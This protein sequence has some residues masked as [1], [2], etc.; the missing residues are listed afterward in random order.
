MAKVQFELNLPGLNELMKSPEM[1]SILDA[2]G[3]AVASAAG[4]D[5]GHRVHQASFV[6]ICNVYPDSKEA[7]KENYEENTL[8][9]A[10]GTV[11]LPTTKS[12]G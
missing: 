3:A 4:P 6:A 9:K 12:G 5:Y 2:A 11:G 8:L 10:I 7:A 1:E